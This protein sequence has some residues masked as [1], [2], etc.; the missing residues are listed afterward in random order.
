GSLGLLALIS[1]LVGLL[2]TGLSLEVYRRA[3]DR[4]EVS[5][6]GSLIELSL[7]PFFYIPL[8]L[9]SHLWGYASSLSRNRSW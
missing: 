7:R 9:L 5:V 1:A 2:L 6:L 4:G 8:N 3:F